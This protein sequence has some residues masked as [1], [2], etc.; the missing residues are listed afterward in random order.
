MLAVVT[1]ILLIEH[2]RLIPLAPKS[3]NEHDPE[4]SSVFTVRLS[5]IQFDIIFHPL[6]QCND[7]NVDWTTGVRFPAGQGRDFFATPS[8]PVLGPTLPSIQ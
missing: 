7:Y 5:E 6:S 1:N 8:R 4:P 2:E 3:T